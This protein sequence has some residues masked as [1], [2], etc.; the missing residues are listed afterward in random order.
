[1]LRS[2]TVSAVSAALVLS[3]TPAS[4]RDLAFVACPIVKDTPSVPCW[5]AEYRGELYYMGVQS[6]VSA[7]FNPPWLGHKALVEGT[8]AADGERICGGIVL[9]PVKV[10]VMPELSP[11]C[12]T[13]LM[14]EPGYVLPFEPRRPPG[15]SNGR[16]AF[17]PPP[18]PPPPEPPF[19][20]RSFDIYFPF[21]G[22][23]NFQTPGALQEV[24]E[25]ARNVGAKRLEIT[26]YRAAVR[27]TD[28]D[29][30][31]EREGIAETRANQVARMFDGLLPGLEHIDVSGMDQA[32]PGDWQDRKV[33]ITVY[34]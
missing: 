3:S 5:L 14:A 24:L 25:Y 9:E 34:P 1:M 11:E 15:P 17:T 21:E 27:L 16:L 23:V 30:I 22:K 6:D 7:P 20:V 18:P 32:R 13:V 28:G 26:G 31:A 19:E 10:S 12:D 29:I 8:P 33:T 4:A 2:L